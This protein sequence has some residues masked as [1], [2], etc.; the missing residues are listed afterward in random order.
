MGALI[1]ALVTVVTLVGGLLAIKQYYD[2]NPNDI[3]GSWTIET[4]TANTT[5]TNYQDMKLV[6][7]VFFTQNGN[8]FTGVGEKTG[9]QVKG[10]PMVNLVG[11]QRT[12][13][14]IT[15]TISNSKIHA[16]FTDHGKIRNSVGQ[17]DWTLRSNAGEGTFSSTAADSSGTSSLARK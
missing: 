5:D 16:N 10:K 1:G 17:F 8:S 4:L 6:Y 12:H 15:G 7:S 9:E 14:D 2:Q 3:Q 11:T 13:I